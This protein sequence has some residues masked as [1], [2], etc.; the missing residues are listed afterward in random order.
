[1]SRG[2]EL[3]MD[4]VLKDA[5]PTSVVL[6][7]VVALAAIGVSVWLMVSAFTA[8][9]SYSATEC[10]DFERNGAAPGLTGIYKTRYV[11]GT[12]YGKVG[13]TGPWWEL[14]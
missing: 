6:L 14:R 1:M 9:P 4:E 10:F 3:M 7:W 5:H 2:K 8:S 11:D 13:A 12:C